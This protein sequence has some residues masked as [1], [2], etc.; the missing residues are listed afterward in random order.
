MLELIK[1]L[2]S[3]RKSIKEK[4]VKLANIEFSIEH[5]EKLYTEILNQETTRAKQEANKIIGETYIRLNQEIAQAKQDANNIL[6]EANEKLQAIND[7]INKQTFYLKETAVLKESYEKA[8][9]QSTTQITK[10]SKIK[11]LYKAM[12]TSINNFFKQDCPIQDLKIPEE[13]IVSAEELAPSVTLKLH[14]MDIP[15]LKKAFK[16]N[17]KLIHETLRKYEDRYTTKANTA[18]YKLM[19]VA[20]EA[21]LQNILYSL[22]YTN[23]DSSLE[24]LQNTT[25]KYLSV[26]SEGNQSI[27]PTLVKFIGEIECLFINA[28]KI[29]YEYYIKKERQKEEQTL[30]REQMRQ[31]AEERKVLEQ[32]K[33]QVEKEEEK[34]KTEIE[35]VQDL[36]SSTTDI[37]KLSTLQNK[38]AE[39]Q[40][41]LN[42]VELKKEE[43]TKRQNGQ[44]GYV[45]VISNLGSFGDNV[46]KVGM[47][48][49]L[50]PQDRINELSGASVPFSF[51]VH[52]FIF[53]DNAV[54]LEQRLHTILTNTRVNKVNLKKE[55]FS[56][57]INELEKIVHNIDPSAEFNTTM[58]AEQYRQTLSLNEE[59]LA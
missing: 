3:L 23:L 5:K 1:E 45:Y 39:L 44:A 59:L 34:Y 32:Q 2:L 54:E 46:F 20:L 30:L 17:D 48:R 49:R 21:E 28:I 53:S 31:E 8:L 14:S 56:L 51:D 41:Q 4:N 25:A 29:E 26:A 35:K 33:K 40:S 7:E 10:L 19:V 43:I 11:I 15:E 42:S 9:K 36:L 13:Y 24:A 22:K 27:A 55:F 12:E 37:E 18:I 38:I 6:E 50:D 58:L 52:S 47:T 16:T 57:P